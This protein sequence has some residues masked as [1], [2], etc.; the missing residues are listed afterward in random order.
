MTS[1]ISVKD[2]LPDVADYSSRKLVA[3]SA[4]IDIAFYNRLDGIWYTDCPAESIEWID[5]ILYWADLP[6]NPSF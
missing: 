3:N 5:K 4:G 1:W 2:R 6:E